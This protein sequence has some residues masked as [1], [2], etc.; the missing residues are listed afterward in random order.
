[1]IEVLGIIATIIIAVCSCIKTETVKGSIIFRAI[2]IV[3]SILFLIYGILLPAL[4][5]ALLNGILVII[6]GYHL[7]LLIIKSKKSLTK[8]EDNKKESY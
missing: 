4:S 2:N 8:T 7:I 6:N 1:M 5:T 3:G